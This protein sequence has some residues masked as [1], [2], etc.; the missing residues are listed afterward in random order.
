ME[1]IVENPD[2]L[3]YV[4]KQLLG[5][6]E[7]KIILLNG[8]L[9]A[10]KT[11]LVKEIVRIQDP[12][13]EVSSPTFSLVNQYQL[14]N[15]PMYHIDLYRI[16]DLNEAMEMGIEEYL[17]DDHIVFIEWPD[18]ILPLL[19]NDYH[20]ITIEVLDNSRRRIKLHESTNKIQL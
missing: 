14:Q 19:D 20:T 16:E 18:V 4:A 7:H 1:F 13:E 17:F 2:E 10:G 3:S 12:S 8:Q 9:G 11:T 5:A 6:F 15:G